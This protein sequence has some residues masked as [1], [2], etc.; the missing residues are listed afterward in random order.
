MPVSAKSPVSAASGATARVSVM[1]G[2]RPPLRA[3]LNTRIAVQVSPTKEV[4]RYSWE[5]VITS[6]IEYVIDHG[7]GRKEFVSGSLRGC[8]TAGT[9]R[10]GR[11]GADRTAGRRGGRS[12]DDGHLY[13]LRQPY[14]HARSDLPAW[15]RDAARRAHRSPRRRAGRVA[16]HPARHRIPAVRPGQ[17]AAVRADVRT[18]AARVRSVDGAAPRGAGHDLHAARRRGRRRATG[19]PAVDRRA[20]RGEHRADPRAAQPAARLLHRLPRSR[21]ATARRRRT[22][23]AQRAIRLGTAAPP[24]PGG[25]APRPAGDRAW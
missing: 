19:V 16:T 7:K 24:A 15:L 6:V 25:A 11:G 5:G 20:W 1:S 17:P 22:G 10:A 9:R 13:P 12:F 8:R 2:T 23:V 14:R 4:S 3:E 21:R 18:A